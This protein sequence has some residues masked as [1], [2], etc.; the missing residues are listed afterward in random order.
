MSF[1]SPVASG[2]PVVHPPGFVARRRTNWIF[3]GL[4][5]GFFLHVALQLAAAIQVALKELYGWSNADYG[6][7]VSAAV[8]V[9]GCSVFLNG[10]I[11]DRI[12]GKKAILIGSAGAAFFNLLFGAYCFIFCKKAP[13]CKTATSYRPPFCRTA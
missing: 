5:Y 6:K 13:S 3:L 10:P 2:S 8:F 9:Y 11:A 12:G 4:M 7:V 1:A